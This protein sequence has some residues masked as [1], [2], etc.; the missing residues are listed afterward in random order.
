M[1]NIESFYV[2]CVKAFHGEAILDEDGNST[3]V[4]YLYEK[5]GHI[6]LKSVAIAA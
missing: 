4:T 1:K 5:N 2:D 3:D 6:T